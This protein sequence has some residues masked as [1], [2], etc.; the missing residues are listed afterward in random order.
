M[1]ERERWKKETLA[2]HLGRSGERREKFL[3]PSGRT[4]DTVYGPDGAGD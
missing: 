2:P 4:V 1:S 3:T